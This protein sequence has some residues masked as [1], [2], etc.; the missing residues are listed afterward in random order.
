MN[1]QE[2]DKELISRYLKGQCTPAEGEFVQ[3]F[4]K[5]PDSRKLFDEVFNED[6]LRGEESTPEQMSEWKAKFNIR[7]QE[8]DEPVQVRPIRKY[9]FLKYAAVWAVMV[10]SAGAILIS[11]IKA[12][13]PTISPAYEV[14]STKNGQITKITLTDGSVIIL[15]ASSRLKYPTAFNAKAREVFLDGEGFFEVVH[16]AKHPFI[17]HAT[18]FNVQ[19]L[20]TSFNI[21]SYFSDKYVSVAV[22]TG[23]VGVLTHGY[24][25]HF[26]T[27]GEQLTFNSVT[28]KMTN[29]VIP[30]ANIFAWQTGMIIAKNETLETIMPQ[31]ERWYG[32][33]VIFKNPEARKIRLSLKQ[34][35][36]TLQ[37]IMKTLSIAGEFH[38]RVENKEVIVW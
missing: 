29:S 31:I 12:K 8:T 26:L 18:H 17:V 7:L 2:V 13:K 34:K 14:V 16:D 25:T 3:D 15:N 20:G 35:Y 30:I 19:V 23:K 36:D 24:P 9:N 22:A 28:Q 5:D 21:R 27:P 32:V 4:L 6:S 11:K 1:D 37:N 33:K 38:Y 10:L